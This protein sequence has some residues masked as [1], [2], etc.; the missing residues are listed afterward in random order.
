VAVRV[1][2]GIALAFSAF[3]EII[4]YEMQYDSLIASYVYTPAYSISKPTRRPT[5]KELI[6]AL[7]GIRHRIGQGYGV[8]HS[9]GSPPCLLRHQAS[10]HTGGASPRTT[11]RRRGSVRLQTSVVDRT[12]RGPRTAPRGYHAC[13]YVQYQIAAC[14]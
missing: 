10:T 14:Q 4:E 8:S 6:E 5:W 9:R 12:G 1:V 7:P 3:I 2:P 11:T 13:Q